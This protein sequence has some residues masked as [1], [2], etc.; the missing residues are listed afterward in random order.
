VTKKDIA[1]AAFIVVLAA[2]VMAM[3]IAAYAV[4]RLGPSWMC[5]FAVIVVIGGGAGWLVTELVE[6]DWE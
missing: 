4:F 2:I 6:E 5:A 3:A 1:C